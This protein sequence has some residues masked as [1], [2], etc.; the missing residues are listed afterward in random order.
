MHDNDRLFI[1]AAARYHASIQSGGP[2]SISEFVASYNPDMRDELAEYLELT[3]ALGDVGPVAS[4]SVVEQRMA[5][6]AAERARARW[7]ARAAPPEPALAAAAEPAPAAAAATLTQ[8]RSARKLTL[9]NLAR[10]INLP[11]DLLARIERGAVQATTI[12]DRLIARLADA[13]ERSAADVRAALG[14][15]PLSPSPVYLS[16][17]QGTSVAAEEVVSFADAL[18]ASGATH[19]QRAEWS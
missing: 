1:E 2:L 5:D 7:R 3:L 4:L 9:G 11:V 8:L 13:L 19:S 10:S 14:A 18:A 15:S 12:P 6:R 16:A 17:D